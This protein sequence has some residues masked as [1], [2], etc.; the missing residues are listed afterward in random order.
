MLSLLQKKAGLPMGVNRIGTTMLKSVAV[1]V[2]SFSLTLGLGI[3]GWHLY[4]YLSGPATL[5]TLGRT[6]RM[7]VMGPEVPSAPRME[8]TPITDPHP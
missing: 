2:T 1:I 7:K 8:V 5:G 6:I 3:G 4:R